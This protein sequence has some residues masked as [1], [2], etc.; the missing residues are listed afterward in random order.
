MSLY[1]SRESSGAVSLQDLFSQKEIAMTTESLSMEE[2]TGLIVRGGWPYAVTHKNIDETLIPSQYLDAIINDDA[3][4]MGVEIRSTSKFRT[5]IESLSRNESAAC[6]LQTIAKDLSYSAN[7]PVSWA[8]V[9]NYCQILENMYFIDNQEP[10]IPRVRSSMRFKKLV[11]RHLA[12]PSL[13][14]ASLKLTSSRLANDRQTLG[15]LF[16]ALAER[17]LRIYANCLGGDLYHYQDYSNREIDAVVCLDDGSWGGFEIKLS[18]NSEDEAAASLLRVKKALREAEGAE[19]TFLCV[20]CGFSGI[21]Y[22][23]QDGVYSVPLNALKP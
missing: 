15:F 11:K 18:R 4:R 21:A 20:L 19:P 9:N 12:D 3:M 23:R 16:E 8:T 1:E 7:E 13:A 14:A 2:L 6:S 17:D 10:F 5:L 22:R